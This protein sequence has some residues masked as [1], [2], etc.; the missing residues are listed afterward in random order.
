MESLQ[1][2]EILTFC[3]CPPAAPSALRRLLLLPPR[4][5]QGASQRR[6]HQDDPGGRRPAPEPAAQARQRR[7]A[8]PERRRLPRPAGLR[9]GALHPVHHLRRPGAPQAGCGEAGEG[10]VSALNLGHKLHRSLP[11]PP[12]AAPRNI[13][14]NMFKKIHYFRI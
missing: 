12:G 13:G 14:L 10:V 11:P 7:D 6:A 4:L 3:L 9:P 2:E 1:A 8:D 5:L